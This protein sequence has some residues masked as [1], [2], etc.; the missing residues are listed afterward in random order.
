[1]NYA[2]IMDSKEFM[3]VRESCI[4]R[5][6]Q[7]MKECVN[8]DVLILQAIS[9]I[10]ELDKIINQLTTRAREWYSWYNPE[11]SRKLVDNE[12]FIELIFK[13]E[14]NVLLREIGVKDSMG[15]DFEKKDVVAI[16]I[17]SKQVYELILLREK[18]KQYLEEILKKHCPNTII[19]LGSQLTAKLIRHAGSLYKLA[20]LPATVIQI[21]GAEKSLFKH[22]SK[23]GKSPK[24]G[25]I[26]SHPL[27]SK[28]SRKD[29][30]KT[31]RAV[32]DKAAIAIRVDYF[33]GEF[34]G[35]EL[36]NSLEKKVNLINKI[37]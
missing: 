17:L 22:L 21:I 30:G 36:K 29:K 32:A 37:R 28:A 23:K 7:I 12:K 5:S 2:K 27:I 13:K 20:M 18:E 26:F 3:K 4:I 34:I 31:A 1:M 16:N 35:Q 19:I 8:D 10:D 25:L 11:F 24:Y 9:C 15:K 6:K 14:K 33:K